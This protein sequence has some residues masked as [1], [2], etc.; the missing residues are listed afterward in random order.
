MVLALLVLPFP[1]DLGKDHT[2]TSHAAGEKLHNPAPLNAGEVIETSNFREKASSR[3]VS[4]SVAILA[5]TTRRSSSRSND[6]PPWRT[7]K[8]FKVYKL[9]HVFLI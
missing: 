5:A 2:V 3:S 1:S 7:G 8:S 4:P 6:R 9:K